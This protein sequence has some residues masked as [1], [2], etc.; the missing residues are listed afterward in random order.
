MTTMTRR[1][2][3]LP[4]DCRVRLVDLPVSAG[5]LI[6]M[7]ET[8]FVNIYLNARLSREAQLRALQHEL[9][10]HYRGDLYS[11]A[12]IRTV[13]R[14]ADAPEL[15]ALDGLPVASPPAGF[16]PEGFRRVGEG[17]YMPTGANL[18]LA[19]AHIDDL[20]RRLREAC[21]VYDVMQFP[22]LIQRDALMDL[23]GALEAGDIAFMA[24]HG[25]GEARPAVMHFSRED[26]YGALYY[27]PDGLPDNALAVLRVGEA[28]VRVDL[29]RRG[30]GLDVCGIVREIG[31]RTERVY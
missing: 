18:A 6:A 2:L 23:A 13:E 16:D 11:E 19:S 27:A 20:R 26:L 3:P 8:G 7:D 29:R 21:L 22:P 12:D 10:H 9:R 1:D 28:K 17:L 5:G 24:W 14:E 25:A 31:E 30:G 4:D 15:V